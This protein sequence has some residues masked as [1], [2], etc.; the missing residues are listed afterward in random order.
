MYVL[1]FT[2][3]NRMYDICIPGIQ[4]PR[5]D[6]DVSVA[7]T[8]IRQPPWSVY[9]KAKRNRLLRLEESGKVSLLRTELLSGSGRI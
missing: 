9:L 1:V 6:Q 5:R 7:A 4:R 8:K 2:E 3:R